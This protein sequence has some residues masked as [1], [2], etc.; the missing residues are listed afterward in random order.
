MSEPI[1]VPAVPPL[2]S[3]PLSSLPISN[4][5]V[6]PNLLDPEDGFLTGVVRE[7]LWEIFVEIGRAWK[8]VPNDSAGLRSSWLEFIEAK[9]TRPPSYVGEYAN[10]VSVVQELVGLMGRE[11]A[12]QRLFFN[13]GVSQKTPPVTR[14]DHVKRYVVDEFIVVQVTASGFRGFAESIFSPNR[15]LNYTGFIRGS[16]YNERPTARLYTPGLTAGRAESE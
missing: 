6:G 5:A 9:T 15:S 7:K 10:A 12:L 13:S 8:N 14:L 2:S 1:A 11:E 3:L 16:R 4:T